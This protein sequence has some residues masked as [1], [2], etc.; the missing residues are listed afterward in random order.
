MIDHVHEILLNG[1]GQIIQ[2]LCDLDPRS[3][4]HTQFDTNSVLM[5]IVPG[6]PGLATKINIALLRSIS[7]HQRSKGFFANNF[8]TDVES[9]DSLTE[10][11]EQLIQ[12]SKQ[13]YGH[14]TDIFI[15][16]GHNEI[17]YKLLNI[18]LRIIYCIISKT[19]DLVHSDYVW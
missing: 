11:K 15:A 1:W 9:C 14:R 10:I 4:S 13:D 3:I 12:F 19:S 7:Q 18:Q 2:I 17:D 8:K 16:S 5:A 6:E